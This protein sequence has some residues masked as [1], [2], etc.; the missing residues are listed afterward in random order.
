VLQAGSMGKGGE[1]F[2]LDMGKPVKIVHLA[3][4]LIRLSGL[5][6]YEDVDITF[7]GL[8]PGEK[9]Y[10]EL[11]L[12]GEGILPTAHEKIR[13]ARAAECDRQALER[14]LEELD[15]LARAL[16]L[17]GVVFKLAEI[18]PEYQPAGHWG[19]RGQ[20]GKSAQVISL[21]RFGRS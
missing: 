11:L 6:P 2:L 21:D 13:V 15:A 14:Q 19:E 12:A 1:I 9:L 18:V 5:R 7:T 16:D 10:E 4:E 8:R 17:N 3:E 20:K